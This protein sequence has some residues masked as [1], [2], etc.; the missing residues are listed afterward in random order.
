METVF[1]RVP[2]R[3]RFPSNILLLKTDTKKNEE[4]AKYSPQISKHAT[5]NNFLK[6][7]FCG[8]L[9]TKMKLKSKK[10]IV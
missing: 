5:G 10:N 6:L 3:N 8:K 2:T 4:K 7:K 9:H 1:P